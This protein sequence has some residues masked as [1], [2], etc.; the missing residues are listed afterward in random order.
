MPI[1]TFYCKNCRTTH[2]TLYRWLCRDGMAVL[3]DTDFEEC[4]DCGEYSCEQL[5]DL[6]TMRPDTFWNGVYIPAI[7]MH[8]SSKS[9]YRRMLKEKQLEVIGDRTDRE[10]LAK[11]AEQGVKEKDKK[12]ERQLEGVIRDLFREEEFGLTGTVKERRKKQQKISEA[13]SANPNDVFED[14]AF[15]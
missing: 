5:P 4:P 2:E 13:E 11:V 12:A 3:P 10:S 9:Q 14:A 6:V 15:K 8:T 1:Y 7:G